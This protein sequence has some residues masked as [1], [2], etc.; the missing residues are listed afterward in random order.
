M[1]VGL[2]EVDPRSAFRVERNGQGRLRVTALP[3]T[4]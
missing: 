1:T 2:G 3:P 4:L